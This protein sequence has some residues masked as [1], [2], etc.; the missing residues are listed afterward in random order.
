MRIV[1][2]ALTLQD[3]V[4]AKQKQPITV[5]WSSRFIHLYS[6]EEFCDRVEPARLARAELIQVGA[7]R[8]G[9]AAVVRLSGHHGEPGAELKVAGDDRNAVFDLI[10][11]AV[12][13]GEWRPLSSEQ[14]ASWGG[15]I[16]AVAVALFAYSSE[17][18]GL[19]EKVVWAAKS[20]VI[21]LLVIFLYA[22]VI[23]ALTRLLM[24]PLEIRSGGPQALNIISGAARW[25]IAGIPA[26]LALVAALSRFVG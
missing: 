16:L 5:K 13:L 7:S 23:R 18:G 9:L 19:L 26:V 1:D 15:V 11:E 17:P 21:F 14:L 4:G 2:L 22:A 6:P 8:D 25:A 20:V 24:P 10:K 3:V 12:E